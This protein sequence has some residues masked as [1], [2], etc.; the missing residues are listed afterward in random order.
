MSKISTA[1][2]I[3][4]LPNYAFTTR[5][6]LLPSVPHNIGKGITRFNESYLVDAR[7]DTTF[8]IIKT[9]TL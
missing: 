4:T 3:L 5:V 2:L 8:M 7:N 9:Y 1:I 6:L